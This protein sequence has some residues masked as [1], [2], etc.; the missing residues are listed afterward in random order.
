MSQIRVPTP[1]RAYTEGQSQLKV[2]ASSVGEALQELT[3]QFPSIA[4]HLY[5]DEGDLRPYVN[6]FVNDQDVRALDGEQTEIHDGDTLMILPSIAGGL[7]GS[8]KALDHS[9]MQT[10]MAVRLG[11][12]L[13][14][15]VVDAPWLVAIASLL[16]LIGTAR[17]R[18]DFVFVYRALR[19]AGWIS[20]D[21][22]PDN[23]EPHRFSLGI[24]GV[25]LA[26][27]TLAFLAGL[28]V[29]GWALTWI[30]I[31]LSALNL[32]GGFC[33]GC[34]AYYWFNRIGLPGFVKAP[35]PG[36]FPGRRPGHPD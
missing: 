23:P 8:L 22:I 28:P 13:A 27:G 14:A 16:M 18:P 34:A 1:L 32:F 12:L 3:A 25:F 31:G 30:V 15:F 17:G 29:A 36:V 5:N 35:P 7:S 33:V 6:L 20:P 10:S 9:A 24:G 2:E 26:G 11:L 21:L 4:P 19:R